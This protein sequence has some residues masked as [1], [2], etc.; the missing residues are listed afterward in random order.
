MQTDLFAAPAGTPAGTP[1]GGAPLSPECAA[2][3]PVQDTGKTLVKRDDLFALHGSCGGKLRLMISLLARAPGGIAAGGR[4]STSAPALAAACRALGRP[5]V[6]HTAAGPDTIECDAAADAVE[7]KRH[8]PG[9]SGV[10]AAR[11]R[12]DSA[13]RGWPVIG[14]E[15]PEYVSMTAAQCANLPWG[16]FNRIVIAAG[17][18]MTLAGILH[19][20]GPR[21]YRVLC[22]EVGAPVAARLGRWAPPWWRELVTIQ[23]SGLR[24][25]ASPPDCNFMGVDLDP[26]YEAKAIRHLQAGDLLWV[27]GKRPVAVR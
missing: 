21:R 24:Y 12:A 19:G 10:I 8:S 5:G 3:T 11:A 18:A 2:L 22:I 9:Y 16:N 15:C 17:T 26:L 6:F 7:I 20:L 27:V 25:D 1:A 23:P 4:R 14:L 13:A